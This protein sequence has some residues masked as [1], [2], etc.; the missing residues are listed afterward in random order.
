MHMCISLRYTVLSKIKI[1]NLYNFWIFRI[2][3]ASRVEI[4][5]STLRFSILLYNDLAAWITFTNK[6][7]SIRCLPWADDETVQ[8]VPGLWEVAATTQHTQGYL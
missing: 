5:L 7:K 6:K 4:F 3:I 1:F 2:F 8:L